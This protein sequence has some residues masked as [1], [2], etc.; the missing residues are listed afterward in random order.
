[1]LKIF[2]V[3]FVLMVF[4]SILTYKQAKDFTVNFNQMRK[5]G[6]ISVGKDKQY[7][8]YGVILI[9]VCDSQGIIVRGKMMRGF[10]VFERFK[11]FDELNGCSVYDIKAEEEIKVSKIKSK[12]RREKGS[13]LLQAV[14]G[15]IS[16]IENV[17]MNTED[18][19]QGEI[20][21]EVIE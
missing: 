8:V 13:A 2:I 20:G 4:N 18:I 14:N 19:Q 17:N 21:G 5:Y 9:L 1:M 10:S 7:F 12:K 6:N 11:D 3:A 16:V 15:L